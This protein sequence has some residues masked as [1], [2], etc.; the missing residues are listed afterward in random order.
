MADSHPF[1]SPPLAPAFWL[2][3]AE[4]REGRHSNITQER[5]KTLDGDVGRV[6]L[7]LTLR[8]V[9][10]FTICPYL[11]LSWVCSVGSY[12]RSRPWKLIGL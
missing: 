12:T 1:T 9:L 6:R 10:S 8:E 7:A 4:Y 11:K 3:D 2:L 5:R